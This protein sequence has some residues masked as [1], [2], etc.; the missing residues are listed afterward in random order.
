MALNF[1]TEALEKALNEFAK[2]SEDAITELCMDGA[3]TMESYAKAHRPWTDR[4]SQA[5]TRLKGDVQHEER[6]K[7]TIGLSH[8]VDYGI[9]L[10]F[11]HERKYAIIQPTIQLKSPE[12]MEAF[13][14]LVSKLWSN[15]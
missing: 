10:E 5:R 13:D 4:T 6:D 9:W 2:Q 12:F 8:G 11:A 7:W 15:L 1:D 3:L 14:G